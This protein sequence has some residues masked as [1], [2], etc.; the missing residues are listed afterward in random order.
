MSPFIPRRLPFHLDIPET[1]LWYNLEVSATRYPNRPALHF[2]NAA[3]SYRE[4]YSPPFQ[5]IRQFL[6][7]PEWT[8]Q[9]AHT[10]IGDF[11]ESPA[12]IFSR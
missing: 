1:S 10:S 9:F 4:K 6:R 2:G 11:H 12:K 7:L 3:I 8:S 5:V